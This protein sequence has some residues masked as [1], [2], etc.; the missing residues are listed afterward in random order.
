MP[1]KLYLEQQA[2]GQIWAM[3]PSLL[4]LG[5]EQELLK[6]SAHLEGG[7]GDRT[8]QESEYKKNAF[9]FSLTT[10]RNLAFLCVWMWAE[11][12]SP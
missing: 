12:Q 8:P 3:Y 6:G 1:V 4:T 5:R 10:D 9:V 2:T 11:H 7:S